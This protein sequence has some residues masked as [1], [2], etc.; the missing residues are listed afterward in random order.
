MVFF[1]PGACEFLHNA[2][3]VSSLSKAPFN[4]EVPAKTLG[5]P[6]R[7]HQWCSL[8]KHGA[9][10]WKI[11]VVWPFKQGWPTVELTGHRTVQQ[12][13]L[14]HSTT[15]NKLYLCCYGITGSQSYTIPCRTSSEYHLALWA[16]GAPY[17]RSLGSYPHSFC[18]M[19]YSITQNEHKKWHLLPVASLSSPLLSLLLKCFL[20]HFKVTT[21][22]LMLRSI[23]SQDTK[24]L[25]S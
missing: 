6:F 3:Y 1:V 21:K 4:T 18:V 22:G 7:H 12:M 24:P 14:L 13:F 9:T 20:M 10:F 25:Q 15:S 5:W 16:S 19:N 2:V 11:S 8:F 17:F 23:C